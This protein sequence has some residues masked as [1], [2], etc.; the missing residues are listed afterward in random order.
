LITVYQLEAKQKMAL[1]LRWNKDGHLGGS[2]MLS[3]GSHIGSVSASQVGL[4]LV[5]CDSCTN[6][7]VKFQ[8]VR[9]SILCFSG[10][11]RAYFSSMMQEQNLV[12]CFWLFKKS[13]CHQD[14]IIMASCI[15]RTSMNAKCDFFSWIVIFDRTWFCLKIFLRWIG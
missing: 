6:M 3:M 7:Y 12:S 13:R 1:H 14:H 2:A 8:T 9:C 15:T 4:W 5:L 10:I 11:A